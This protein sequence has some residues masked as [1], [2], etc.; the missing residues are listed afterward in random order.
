MKLILLVLVVG[1]LAWKFSPEVQSWTQA[2]LS[3]QQAASQAMTAPKLISISV[4]VP[5]KCD[6]RKRCSQMTS[7]AEAMS[8]LQNCPGMEMDGDDDGVPC[9]SQ[10]CR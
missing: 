1:V 6:G 3:S 4:S 9:E 5:V 8:F 2:R 7:C 10:W